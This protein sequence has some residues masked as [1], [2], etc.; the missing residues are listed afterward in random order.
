MHRTGTRAFHACRDTSDCVH[1]PGLGRSLSTYPRIFNDSRLIGW[2]L[3]TVLE[4]ASR[5]QVR[6]GL[7]AARMSASGRFVPLSS[8]STYVKFSHWSS[9]REWRWVRPAAGE[10]GQSRDSACSLNA[11][12]TFGTILIRPL[13]FCSS[14]PSDF[15]HV[16]V[17]CASAC[18][19]VCVCRG[20]CCCSVW[21]GVLVDAFPPSAR[22]SPPKVRQAHTHS[23]PLRGITNSRA[24]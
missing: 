22:R 7:D 1:I 6:S 2:E 18:G 14:I 15:G 9:H 21:R 23:L 11:D 20:V 4:S 17:C 12:L 5:S 13:P 10:L 24:G 16:C 19:S 8:S 3:P